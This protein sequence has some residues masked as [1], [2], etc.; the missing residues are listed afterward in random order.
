M[1]AIQSLMFYKFPYKLIVTLTT[2]ILLFN[3]LENNKHVNAYQ[4]YFFHLNT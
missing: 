2:F 4:N 1:P 3:H